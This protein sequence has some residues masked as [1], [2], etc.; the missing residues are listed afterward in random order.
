MSI[1]CSLTSCNNKEMLPFQCSNCKN[2][3]CRKHHPYDKHECSY[4]NTKTSRYVSEEELNAKN[5]C[6]VEACLCTDNLEICNICKKK[7]CK[8]HASP[9]HVC[10]SENDKPKSSGF[11]SCLRKIFSSSNI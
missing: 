3:Y 7:F 9:W 6:D 4:I 5:K 2:F 1:T 10:I 11:F 8:K